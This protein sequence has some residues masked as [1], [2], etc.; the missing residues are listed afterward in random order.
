MEN[1][2]ASAVEKSS[3]VRPSAAVEK[4]I[5]GLSQFIAV[6][7]SQVAE[8]PSALTMSIR[9][10][11]ESAEIDKVISLNSGTGEPVKFTEGDV[12]D[13]AANYLRV[14]NN[15]KEAVVDV[16]TVVPPLLRKTE[17]GRMWQRDK[18]KFNYLVET[19]M[20][21]IKAH[22]QSVVNPEVMTSQP[23]RPQIK[24]NK[25]PETRSA[26]ERLIKALGGKQKSKTS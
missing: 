6:S 20:E 8:N 16:E 25:N 23:E 13:G 9:D 17:A 4:S 2:Q 19:S 5:R 10:R 26:I 1:V 11:T 21:Q 14:N 12:I 24:L 15:S 18:G 3:S 7:N 22:A